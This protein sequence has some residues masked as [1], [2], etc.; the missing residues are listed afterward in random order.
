[1]DIAL[2]LG[3]GGV[4]GNAHIGV[5]RVLEREG[6]RIRAIAGT[7]AGGL[8]GAVY[9]SGFSP[10]EMETHMFNVDHRGLFRRV[11]HAPPSLL[12]LGGLAED[13]AKLVG[14]RTFEDLSAPFAVVA[15]DLRNGQEVI[16]RSG[17][18]ID[19][20]M[21]TVAVPGVFPP[22]ELDEYILVDGAVSNP[23]PVAVARTLVPN[24]PVVA[25]A[26]S[27]PIDPVAELDSINIFEPIPVLKQIARF[28]VAQ[29]F[30]VFVRS[31]EISGNIMTRMRLE[32][33]KPEVCIFPD[34]GE[35]GTLQEVDVREVVQRGEQ[36]AE[37]ALDD[38]HRAVSWRGNLAR[39]FGI[40]D[41]LMGGNKK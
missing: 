24:L 31:V 25:V 41:R 39:K 26:L 38:L 10:D 37:D 7:S 6:F 32:I 8:V 22:K 15:V 21:A 9:L 36:A 4:R 23:V 40:Y 5:L 30:N 13:L 2:A 19:A 27:S 29:A 28:R 1:M 3:G 14:D 33:D 11:Q 34:V 17:R 35:Y 16:L 20:L 18:V 12:G